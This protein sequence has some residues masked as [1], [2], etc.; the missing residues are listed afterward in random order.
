MRARRTTI[1]L[2]GAALVACRGETAADQRMDY[3]AS[4]GAGGGG[5]VAEGAPQRMRADL[6][7]KLVSQTAFAPPQSM[8]DGQ[9]LIRTAELVIEVAHVDSALRTADSIAKQLDA[10]VADVRVSQAENRRGT[11][12]LVVR[13]AASNFA[14][15]MA[16]LRELGTVKHEGV[17]TQDI[18]KEYADLAVRVAVKQDAVTRLRS[19]LNSRPG[20][21]SDVLDVERELSRAVTEFEQLKGEQR[22]YD[23]RVA[24]STVSVNLTE[25]GTLAR[26]GIM[27]T[28]TEALRRSTEVLTTS[29]AMLI[30]VVTF[31]IPWIPVALLVY[32][33]RHRL[34]GLLQRVAPAGKAA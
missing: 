24:V 23:E 31:L 32:A 4:T 6:S 20:K 1:V 3:V 8:W 13:V 2:F 7:A 34:R 28:I 18:T 33:L 5:R 11:A 17:S 15:V 10:F 27:S 30:Y 16:A 29:V 22:Y 25:P 12:Q 26:P 21:L 9:K 19:I 14:S